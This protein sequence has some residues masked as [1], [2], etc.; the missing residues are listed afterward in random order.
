MQRHD[1][2]IGAEWTAGASYRPNLTPSNLADTIAEYTQG[3]AT[4]RT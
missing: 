2:L 3:D 1:S 4:R